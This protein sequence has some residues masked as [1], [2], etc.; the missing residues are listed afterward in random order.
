MAAPGQGEEEADLYEVLGVP[1][2]VGEAE[3]K[4][5]YRKLALRFHPDKNHGNEEAAAR[6]KQISLAY[7]VLS[8]PAK[9]RWAVRRSFGTALGA[10][11]AGCCSVKVEG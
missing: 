10:S 9:R 6:F 7:N 2:D 4:K 3:L 1:R 8:D 5:V 11:M